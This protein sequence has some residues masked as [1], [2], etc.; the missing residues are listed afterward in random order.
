MSLNIQGLLNNLDELKYVMKKRRPDICVCSETHITEDVL[1][2]E[3]EI[4]GYTLL[5]TNSQSSRTGGICIYVKKS[6][7]IMNS[8]ADFSDFIWLHS[9][10]LCVDNNE[11][12]RMVGVYMSATASKID[13]LNY[14]EDWCNN[15]YE[16]G[17]VLVCG[18]FNI[19]MLM[20]TSHKER[21]VNICNDIGL[22]QLVKDITRQTNTSATIIDLCFSN[23]RLDASVLID[24]QISDHRNV[25]LIMNFPK[26]KERKHKFRI[27]KVWRGY[28]T[29]SLQSVLNT[30]S[31][32]WNYIKSGTCDTKMQWLINKLT[33]TS[34]HFME[35]KRVREIDDFFDNELEAMRNEKNQLYKMAQHSGE[36]NDWQ[37][38]RTFRNHY[39]QTIKQKKYSRMQLRLDEVKGDPKKTWRILNSILKENKNDFD[40]IISN[41]VVYEDKKDISNEFNK[42]FVNAVTEI[43]EN[44]PNETYVDIINHVNESTFEFKPIS[45]SALKIYL[46]QLEKKDSKDCFNISAQFLLDCSCVIGELLADVINSSFDS[47]CFPTVLKESIIVPIQK[48]S[49]TTRIEDFRPINTLPCIEKVIEKIAYDQFNKFISENRVICDEQ[50]GFRN[51]HSCESALSYII[52]DWKNCMGNDESILAVF[53][54]FQKAFETIDRNLLIRKL[55]KY[56][57]GPRAIEWFQSYLS[58]RTQRVK[59]SDAISDALINDLGVPQGSVLG[60]L[61]FII[62]INDLKKSLQYCNIKFFADDTLIYIGFKD[63]NDGQ[64][65]INNDLNNIYIAINQNKLKLNVKKTKLMIITKKLNINKNLIDIRIDNNR[66]EF[67]N[68]LKYLGVI[69]DDNLD[70]KKNCNY[71]ASKMARKNGLL[72][73]IGNS[74]NMQ[75]KIQ[76]YKT[77]IEPHLNYCS[78][79]LFLSN[80]EDI[81]RLQKIQN[82][83]MRNILKV[84]RRYSSENLLKTLEFLS[85]DQRIKFNTLVNIFKIVNKISPE[86]LANKIKLNSDNARKAT[87]RNRNLI[88]TNN[89]TRGYT[90]NSLFYKGINMYNMLSNECKNA[91]NVGIFKSTLYKNLHLLN[92]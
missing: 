85:V 76:V 43:N 39:K 55:K 10:D 11:S 36:E 20:N 37:V 79:I 83:C 80:K 24:D 84:D 14:F 9:F 54:D 52:D 47:S 29:D 12:V 5:R 35:E 75:Q 78:T 27:I 59:F 92:N 45:V 23:I 70:F 19:D 4:K 77:T 71:V 28:S 30:W 31:A 16:S 58:D 86:Y 8:K 17:N 33:E 21:L 63:V 69:L 13:I 67:V 25:E 81:N 26:P 48:V 15:N 41:G 73:R 51:A 46:K 57:V 44:I 65:K 40:H 62:Y 72:M 2:S 32:Q 6:L 34:N 91:N 22:D 50:S 66:L 87:L 1:N 53:L 90:Q 42:Y 74:L 61:L 64:T 56:G 38:Y 18:D 82:R 88:Q 89:A 49:G 7:K 60:P 68:E 3:I